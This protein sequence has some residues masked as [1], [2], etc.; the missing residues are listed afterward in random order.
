MTNQKPDRDKVRKIRKQLDGLTGLN[1]KKKIDF[2]F[3]GIDSWEKG[4]NITTITLGFYPDETEQREDGE[5]PKYRTIHKMKSSIRDYRSSDESMEIVLYPCKEMK[6]WRYFNMQNINEFDIIANLDDHIIKGIKK[7]IRKMTTILKRN[8][9]YRKKE[10]A[11]RLAKIRY[12]MML[13]RRLLKRL[14][15]RKQI[16]VSAEG[17]ETYTETNAE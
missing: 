8:P 15:K 1:M 12:E 16:E 6:E 9:E 14:E 3:E 7:F 10:H 13:R 4:Y 2:V 11:E 17:G 5:Y